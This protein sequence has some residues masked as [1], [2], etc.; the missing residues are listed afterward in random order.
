MIFQ[1]P[2][3]PNHCRILWLIIISTAI[4]S[5]TVPTGSRKARMRQSTGGGW[6]G[7]AT[8][9]E[10]W[11]CSG[12]TPADVPSAATYP[13]EYRIMESAEVENTQRDHWVQ[14]LVLHRTSQ[15]SHP[16]PESIAQMFLELWQP[17]GH[18][19]SPVVFTATK[20]TCHV[21]SY[22]PLWLQTSSCNK[23]STL[24]LIMIN[25]NLSA[26]VTLLWHPFPTRQVTAP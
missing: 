3:N 4:T 19:C 6:E 22:L 25:M 14:F 2:C 13:V 10:P 23:Y 5:P 7:A 12:L 15:Q 21:P 24:L 9:G 1:V 17:W 20:E 16:V 11:M 26:A 18:D 8:A